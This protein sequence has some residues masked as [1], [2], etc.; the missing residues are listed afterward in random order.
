[1]GVWGTLK[2][3]PDELV[4]DD[5]GLE[6]HTPEPYDYPT[7]DADTDDTTVTPA[8]QDPVVPT[9]GKAFSS[10]CTG[11]GPDREAGT[12][13]TTPAGPDPDVP[14]TGSAFSSDYTGDGPSAY[15]DDDGGDD[16]AHDDGYCVVRATPVTTHAADTGEGE[17]IPD[18]SPSKPPTMPEDDPATQARAIDEAL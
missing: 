17:P 16:G 3:T 13:T 12:M 2:F 10:D 5:L 15:L 7:R 6:V 18:Q 1:M 14:T 4:R 11:D 8:G 9:T